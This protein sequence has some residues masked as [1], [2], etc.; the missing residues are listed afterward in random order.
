MTAK[1]F[2]S[3]N[4]R[5][6]D[7][8]VLNGKK[9]CFFGGFKTFEGTQPDLDYSIF[10]VFYAIGKKGQMVRRSA[11]PGRL[12]YMGL[13]DVKFIC[14]AHYPTFE[15]TMYNRFAPDEKRTEVLQAN[16]PDEAEEIINDRWFP[17]GWGVLGSKKIKD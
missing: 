4:L 7:L 9:T 10:P 3:R 8:V 6:G 15:V 5:S 13:S 2:L 11:F 12:P 17:K 1:E 14:K 16:S